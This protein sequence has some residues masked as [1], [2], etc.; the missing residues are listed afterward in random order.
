MRTLTLDKAIYEALEQEMTVD[1]KVILLGEDIGRTCS[2]GPTMGLYEKFGPSR[3]LETPISE[4]ALVGAGLG[5]ALTGYKSVVEIMGA[6][7]STL[8]LDQIVNHAAKTYYLSGGKIN[9]PLVIRN[10]CGS[11]R[12]A[13]ADHSQSLEAWYIHTPGLKVV[14][15]STPFD[16][17]GL[18]IAAIRNN[19]PIIYFEHKGLY[20]EI[21]NVP[22]EK[23]TVEIGKG[24]IVKQGKDITILATLATVPEAVKAYSILEKENISAEIIDPR[25]LY[26]LDLELILSSVRKTKNLIVVQDA[27]SKCSFASEVIAQV[28]ENNVSFENPPGRLTAPDTP[29]P[30]SKYL[31]KEYFSNAEK[32]AFAVKNQLKLINNAQ[33]GK[34]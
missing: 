29:I 18:L 9:V 7:W 4:A 33:G 26:P 13:G 34:A 11:R 19:N 24:N 16:A 10:L 27:P 32:I 8:A 3:V 15:P 2:R 25:T 20:S 31:E 30:C 14:A 22:E 21:G 23:Y 1:D 12:G 5:A 28:V 17:K 6:D